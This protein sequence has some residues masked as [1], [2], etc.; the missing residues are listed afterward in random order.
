MPAADAPQVCVIGAG[1]SGL[2][3]VKALRAAGIACQGFEKGGDV[4][5]MWR[6]QN[7]SGTSSCYHSLHIDSSRQSLGFPDFAIPEDLPDYLSHAQVLEH[8]ERY[9]DRHDLR[10]SYAFNTEVRRVS[11]AA[12]G[13]WEIEIAPF[14]GA[15]AGDAPT[16]TRGFSHVVIANGHLWD[17]KYPDFPGAFDGEITHSHHYRTAA[18]FEGKRVLVV[19]LGNSAVDIAVDVARRAEKTFMSTRRSAWILPKYIMGA[20]TDRWLAFFTRKLRLPVPAAREAARRLAR[21]T[22]GGQERF[23]VPLPE[24]PIWR[25]HATISQDLLP[26]LGHGWIEMRPNIA[27][28][29]GEAVRFVDGAREAVD[30]IIYATGYRTSFPFLDTAIFAVEEGRPPALYR[31]MVPSEHP[32]LFFSGLVQPV[33]PTIP[34]VEIQGR[35]IASVLSGGAALPDRAAMLREIEAHRARNARRYLD[36]GR[37]TLEV[38]FKDYAAEMAADLAQR[39]AAA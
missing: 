11:P 3:A 4:G 9:A 24:H 22:F 17:P 7:D 10:G 33:G 8:F 1:I 38:D 6:Y 30:A 26:Y 39:R 36:S 2:T 29:E 14:A 12:G 5:G 15:D 20:P 31:R 27:R 32:S 21:L 23:G 35:W 16:E 28:L 25:E 18:P 37:Y 34:L 19:G 13:G